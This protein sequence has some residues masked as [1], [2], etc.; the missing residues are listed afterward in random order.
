MDPTSR[1]IA[2]LE[3]LSIT[4]QEAAEVR[5]AD[6]KTFE[7]D[8]AGPV[9]DAIR[10]FRRIIQSEVIAAIPFMHAWHLG[11][12][13]RGSK[14]HVMHLLE[15]V[16]AFVAESTTQGSK[17][18][19]GRRISVHAIQQ[20]LNRDAI[21]DRPDSVATAVK[22]LLDESYG[23]TASQRSV[24]SDFSQECQRVADSLRHVD[25]L[26]WVSVRLNFLSESDFT[27]NEIVDLVKDLALQPT[28][29]NLVQGVNQLV[30][31]IRSPLDPVGLKQFVTQL[32][33]IRTYF[34]REE[35]GYAASHPRRTCDI[36]VV[37]AGPRHRARIAEEVQAAVD[38]LLVRHF[39]TDHFAAVDRDLWR[40]H[41]TWGYE[42]Y[43]LWGDSGSVTSRVLLGRTV[44]PDHIEQLQSA[45]PRPVVGVD[46]SWLRSLLESAGRVLDLK[47]LPTALFDRCDPRS[48]Q[49]TFPKSRWLFTLL[50]FGRKPP[51]GLDINVEVVHS[52]YRSE[53]VKTLLLGGEQSDS[54]T[55]I[56]RDVLRA[57][58]ALID[59][60]VVESERLL[61]KGDEHAGG[62]LTPTGKDQDSDP[63]KPT[64]DEKR[65]G[66]DLPPAKRLGLEI[67]F[68][69]PDKITYKECS[70]TLSVDQWRGLESMVGTPSLS[71]EQFITAVKDDHAAEPTSG[72]L[73]GLVKRINAVL[74]TVGYTRYLGRKS[75]Y[76]VWK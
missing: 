69:P 63:S 48:L 15:K 54:Y 38:D 11:Q 5:K 32:Q 50:D 52:H 12:S 30:A 67:V 43:R 22:G 8:Y 44:L 6:P 70:A 28:L 19:A 20:S 34:V 73:K 39:Q 31:I 47:H 23:L 2:C 41:L 55:L 1:V 26:L 35:A 3:K 9:A 56:L 45:G 62:L 59:W 60:L 33:Q 66:D 53:H 10:E 7:R 76:I 58:I 25:A 18:A 46:D 37:H 4:F 71:D 29:H 14:S 13:V 74:V 27:R 65:V 64:E 42:L 75:G 36:V 24:V 68:T 16:R 40:S 51:P 61:G 21:H 72:S 57:S 17:R 49:P